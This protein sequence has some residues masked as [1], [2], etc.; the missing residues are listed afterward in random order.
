MADTYVPSSDNGP[1]VARYALMMELLEYHSTVTS[2]IDYLRSVPR[3]GPGNLVLAD[4]AGEMAV[5][6]AGHAHWGVVPASGDM[7][8]ATNHFVT[9]V[10]SE[11][12]LRHERG[13]TEDE[14]E[15]RHHSAS[16]QLHDV[17][18]RIDG[19]EARRIMSYHAN[20]EGG[21]CRHDAGASGSTISSVI[22]FPAER[23]L[24]FCHG[25][26]CEGTYSPHS[27]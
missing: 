23:S 7:V 14:S 26:P 10:L 1:G 6:E 12:N 18:G 3:M 20:T 11:Y 8:V 24:L 25:R 13:G 5:F 15:A 19:D 16:E 21:L 17:W 22:F 2:A 4:A 9:P 27:L